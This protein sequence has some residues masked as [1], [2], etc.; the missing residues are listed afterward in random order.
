MLKTF[1]TERGLV[2]LAIRVKRQH[3]E[4]FLKALAA[5]T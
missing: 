1:D 3:T 5:A 2:D 4:D